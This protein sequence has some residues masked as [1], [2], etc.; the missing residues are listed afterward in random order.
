MRKIWTVLGAGLILSGCSQV[1]SIMEKLPFQQADREGDEQAEKRQEN[2]T[3]DNLDNND[4]GQSTT[5]NSQTAENNSG[6]ETPAS[7]APTLEAAYFNSI[8]EVNGRAIIQNPIN[9]MALVNKDFALPDGYLP[10][11]MV[12]PNVPFSYGA[13]DIEK[14]Y[15]RQEASAALENLFAEANR[16]GLKLYAVS[17]YRSYARQ[18]ELFDAEV[19]RVGEQNA[20]Q[21]VAVPG[22]SEHQTGLAMDISSQS[23]GL[24]LTEQFGETPEG[25][26]LAENAHRFGFILR[27]PKGKEAITGYQYEPWHFRFVGERDAAVIYEKKLTLEEYF[28]IV[29]KI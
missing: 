21:V 3:R 17:G 20:K 2:V 9:I 14:S 28:N 27:Y 18:K 1:E 22:N 5:E 16:N 12:R 11:T 19:S 13:Q 4:T 24:G 8:I 6:A 23:A 25:K 29:L 10:E 7:G 26:W 15:L